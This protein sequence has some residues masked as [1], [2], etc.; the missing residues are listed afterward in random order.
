MYTI[1]HVVTQEQLQERR[2]AALSE[3]N[4]ATVLAALR[5]ENP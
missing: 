1:I 2:V 5:K 3:R 4:R